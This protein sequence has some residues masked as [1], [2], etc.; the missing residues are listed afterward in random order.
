MPPNQKQRP[1]ESL[2]AAFSISRNR[3]SII[4]LKGQAIHGNWAVVVAISALFATKSKKR[5]T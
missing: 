3:Y 2:C 1:E 4:Y 5:P